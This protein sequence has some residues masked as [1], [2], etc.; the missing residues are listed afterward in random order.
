MADSDRV[1]QFNTKIPANLHKQIKAYCA[2]A[3]VRIQDFT[4]DAFEDRL[5]RL[6]QSERGTVEKVLDL[7]KVLDRGTRRQR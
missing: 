5:A 1:E 2:L 7:R 4:R 6:K 3:K